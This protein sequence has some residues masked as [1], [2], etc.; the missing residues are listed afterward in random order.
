MGLNSNFFLNRAGSSIF[1]ALLKRRKST[2]FS[3]VFRSLLL[4]MPVS[5]IYL[6][7]ASPGTAGGAFGIDRTASKFIQPSFGPW[8]ESPASSKAD[9]WRLFNL[10]TSLYTL[11]ILRLEKVS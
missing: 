7:C 10:A 6:A 1:E 3:L 2:A 5:L 11:A 4:A 8:L 9:R